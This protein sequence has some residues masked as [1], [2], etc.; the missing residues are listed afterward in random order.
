MIKFMKHI[1]YKLLYTCEE[2]TLL[3]EKRASAES[4]S[5]MERFR[6]RGHL[7]MCKWCNAYSKKVLLMDKAMGRISKKTIQNVQEIE[8]VE[9]QKRLKKSVKETR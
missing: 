2:A 4:L 7:A 1:M 6:L 8:L 5:L 9:F 3:I